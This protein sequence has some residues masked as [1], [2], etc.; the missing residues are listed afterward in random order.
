MA[1]RR[2]SLGSFDAALIEW[3]ESGGEAGPEG[4]Y[5]LGWAYARLSEKTRSD[6][7]RATAIEYFEAYLAT[8][9][10]DSSRKFEVEKALRKL[11]AGGS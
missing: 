10:V 6:K 4:L 8:E 9:N 2:Q 5:N 7:D 3:S 1:L 11:K